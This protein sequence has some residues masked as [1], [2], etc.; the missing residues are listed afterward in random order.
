MEQL[1]RQ[2]MFL[3]NLLNPLL[4]LF[5]HS[6]LSENITF[7]YLFSNFEINVILVSLW[8][9]LLYE[10]SF[11]RSSQP[12]HSTINFWQPSQW[13][14]CILSIRFLCCFLLI[15]Y[16]NSI[17]NFLILILT[18]SLFYVHLAFFRICYLAMNISF[19][20]ALESIFYRS[21]GFINLTNH[22][23]DRFSLIFNNFEN[24]YFLLKLLYKDRHG[25]LV[26]ILR[27]FFPRH[28][29]RQLHV[30]V[31]FYVV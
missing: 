26:E 2:K 17:R 18:I 29:Q 19:G 14:S 5:L 28:I 16:L 12:Q 30:I 21:W 25:L 7:F 4:F 27:F 10:I 3:F 8:F 20:N 9:V 6:F 24:L 23:K 13:L 31:H 11:Y 1:Q 22:L 15:F